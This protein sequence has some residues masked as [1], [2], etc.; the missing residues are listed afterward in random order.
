MAQDG[1]RKWVCYLDGRRQGARSTRLAA[2][3]LVSRPW[4]RGAA[5]VLHLGTGEYWERRGG[6]WFKLRATW[7][8]KGE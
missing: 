2:L 6:S 4:R 8:N 5:C 3:N 1:A 7:A